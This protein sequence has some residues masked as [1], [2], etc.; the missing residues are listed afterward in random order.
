MRGRTKC[1]KKL[2]KKVKENKIEGKETGTVGTGMHGP[3]PRG[4]T[5]EKERTTAGDVLGTRA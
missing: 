3:I 2:E 5:E 4:A 1:G